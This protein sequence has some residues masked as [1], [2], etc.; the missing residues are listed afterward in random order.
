MTFILTDH[1]FRL[2]FHILEAQEPYYDKGTRF[3]GSSFCKGTLNQ[4]KR[5]GYHWATKIWKQLGCGVLDI[6]QVWG[7]SVNCSAVSF[8]QE[9]LRFRIFFGCLDPKP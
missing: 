7:G 6:G 5:K 4:K 9:R 2:I 3:L 8:S 1:S